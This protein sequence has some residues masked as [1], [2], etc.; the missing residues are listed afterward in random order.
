MCHRT[1]SVSFR[2]FNKKALDV[3]CQ[4]LGLTALSL[5]PTYVVGWLAHARCGFCHVFYSTRAR[6]RSLLASGSSA[7]ASSA[8]A[9]HVD[10]YQCTLR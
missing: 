7:N 2:L 3:F 4:P 10:I 1:L 5:A 8:V 9:L 6:R